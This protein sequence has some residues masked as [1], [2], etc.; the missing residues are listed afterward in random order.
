MV[1]GL[2]TMAGNS[3][4]LRAAVVTVAVLVIIIVVALVIVVVIGAPAV[5][6]VVIIGTTAIVIVVG[7]TVCIRPVFYPVKINVFFQ[8]KLPA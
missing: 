1:H 6:L 5:V 2:S 3:I 7:S 4:F 8:F